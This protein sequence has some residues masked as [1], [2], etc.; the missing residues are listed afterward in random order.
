MTEAAERKR[1]E[2]S[3]RTK[4]DLYLT[5]CT[6][7]NPKWTNKLNLRPE[8]KKILEENREKTIDIGLNNEFLD[9]VSKV[10]AIKAKMNHQDYTHITDLWKAKIVKR[11]KRQPSE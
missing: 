6:K 10:Q 1:Q 11:L 3:K 4:G 8:T 5:P 9:T 7:I 2:Y